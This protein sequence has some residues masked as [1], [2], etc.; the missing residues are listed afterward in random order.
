MSSD[1]SRN[2]LLGS[3]HEGDDR[4]IRRLAG[5]DVEKLDA[6]DT[7]DLRCDLFNKGLVVPFAEVGY[8]FNELLFHSLEVLQ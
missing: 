7:L 1:R 4:S 6:F 8:T 5:I 2:N 3:P